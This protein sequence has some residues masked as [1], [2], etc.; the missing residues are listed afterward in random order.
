MIG[1]QRRT[2]PGL[3]VRQELND[4][5]C[6]FGRL[7]VTSPA[8]TALDLARR[9]PRDEAVIRL[10]QLAAATA[11]TRAEVH[12]L[13]ERY[14]GARGWHCPTRVCRAP[15]P[16]SKSVTSGRG[17]SS[18]SAGRDS[19]S[20]WGLPTTAAVARPSGTG[21][22]ISTQWNGMAGSTSWWTTATTGRPSCAAC[23]QRSNYSG[24]R[25]TGHDMQRGP[26]RPVPSSDAEMAS[27]SIPESRRRA[28]VSVFRS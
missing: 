6:H 5:I 7:P 14:T 11:M 22:G 16:V 3:I 25:A 15:K 27:T 20:A 9:L 8:R 19:R 10:D 21:S 12:S 13:A 23:G 1:E 4:E 24:S 26:P 18:L 17:H 28:L 2:P